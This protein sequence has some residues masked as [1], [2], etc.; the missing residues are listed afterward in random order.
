MRWL[1]RFR[2][3]DLTAPKDPGEVEYTPLMLTRLWR[4]RQVWRGV[5]VGFCV[6]MM[7]AGGL[8]VASSLGNDSELRRQ[9]DRLEAAIDEIVKVRTDAR[10]TE[11][12]RDNAQLAKAIQKE[13]DSWASFIFRSFEAQ[14]IEP[15]ESQ[16]EQIEP[17]LAEQEQ[18]VRNEY[19]DR[20]PRPCTSDAI[21]EFYRRRAAAASPTT[22]ALR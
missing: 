1:E 14:G 8:F 17:F 22:T 13:R 7:F 3:P 11:C 15:T 21:E 2:Q 9:N 6:A 16:R 19:S 20:A 12:V 10:Y 4:G 18:A 5:F